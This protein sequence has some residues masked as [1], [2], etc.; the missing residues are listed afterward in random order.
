MNAA[1]IVWLINPPIEDF[2]AS[3]HFSR[4]AGLL[5][6]AAE[7][8]SAGCRLEMVDCLQPDSRSKQHAWREYINIPIAKPEVFKNIPRYYHHYGLTWERIDALLASLPAPRLV[9]VGAGM[10]YWY[11]SVKQVIARVR[12]LHPSAPIALGGIYPT[13][14]PDHASTVSGADIVV[15]GVAGD[16][17]RRWATSHLDG[18]EIKPTGDPPAWDL[19]DHQGGMAVNTSR[20]CPHGCGYC[21]AKLSPRRI[22]VPLS[23]I[24]DEL[25]A[26][27]ERFGGTS[28]AIYDDELALG[29]GSHFKHFLQGVA[30]LPVRFQWHLPNAVNAASLDPELAILMKDCGFTQPRLSLPHMDRRMGPQG[31][32]TT[33]LRHMQ[34][35]AS[36]FQAAGYAPGVLSFYLVTGL[37]DQRLGWVLRAAQQLADLG[38]KS[39]QS[40]FS[41]I[42]GTPLGDR[43]LAQLNYQESKELLL[44]NKALSVYRHPNWTADEYSSFILSLRRLRD[45]IRP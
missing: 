32:D 9:L 18:L 41:P 19:L 45:S 21:G 29:G 15:A 25:T 14:A 28:V 27:H 10:T 38:I 12:L 40:Q 2:S 37:P 36:A 7:L 8:R 3:D 22:E 11:S 17:F 4:P 13:L 39:Y 24:F 34:L 30:K 44:T 6:V 35:A 20:G 26:L 5:R 31:L 43:R 42:P 16:T 23:R 33:A 1:P